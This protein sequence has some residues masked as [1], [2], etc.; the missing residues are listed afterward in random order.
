MFDS[1]ESSQREFRPDELK[2]NLRE[3]SA[4]CVL[5]LRDGSG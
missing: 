1:H 3:L 5:R 2:L 4:L